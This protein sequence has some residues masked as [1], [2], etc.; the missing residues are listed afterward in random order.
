LLVPA[1]GASPEAVA[2]LSAV[3]VHR[4]ESVRDSYGAFTAGNLDWSLVPR[5]SAEEA[6]AEFGDDA[7]RSF[8]AEFFFG[9]NLDAPTLSDRRFR[10]AIVRS[11][12]REAL[13]EAIDPAGIALNGVVVEGVDGHVAD[14]CGERCEFDLDAAADLLDEV[15]GDGDVP[16]VRIDYFDGERERAIAEAVVEDLEAAGI[17]AMARDA[18][19]EDYKTFVTSGDQQVFLFGWVGVAPSA[20]SYLAPL[21]SSESPDNVTGF[22]SIIVDAGIAA[23]RTFRSPEDRAE[24]YEIVE[25]AV[26]SQ[27]PVVPV[28]QVR[29]L[30]VVSDRVSGW[31]ARLDGTVVLESV[32]VAP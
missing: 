13:A 15:F 17:P 25:R 27:V 22:R 8:H 2:G 19:E 28:V 4:F 18:P 1:P 21:F 30:A 26:M 20:D 14:P 10:E 29:T 32:S 11:L 16:E 31:Q 5:A 24:A 9:I 12:D 23:A 3:E 6:V 7:F